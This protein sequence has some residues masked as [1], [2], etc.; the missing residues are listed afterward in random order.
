MKKLAIVLA[1][2][3][4]LPAAAN[5]APCR[6]AQGHFT[7]CPPA[8]AAHATP[9]ARAT[10]AAHMA[11]AGRPAPAARTAMAARTVAAPAGRK[12]QCRDAKGRFKK[13]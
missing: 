2:F 5:A 11:P 8:G 7:K 1:A 12:P 6:N 13:C 3:V 4:A 10:P 9:A